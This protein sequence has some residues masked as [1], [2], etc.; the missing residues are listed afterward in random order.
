MRISTS[1]SR[2][3]TDHRNLDFSS[4]WKVWRF[5]FLGHQCGLE[6]NRKVICASCSTCHAWRPVPCLA[7]SFFPHRLGMYEHLGD[8]SEWF[9][10][11][12]Q[13]MSFDPLVA[14][15]CASY[16][17]APDS[18]A[19]YQG[20]E[21]VCNDKLKRRVVGGSVDHWFL[22][23]TGRYLKGVCTMIGM[24]LIKVIAGTRLINGIWGHAVKLSCN[25]H[26]G[27]S[28]FWAT[29]R[30]NWNHSFF[31]RR[32]SL[33]ISSNPLISKCWKMQFCSVSQ[34]DR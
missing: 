27:G 3:L 34:R 11:F 18:A 8:R 33:M 21:K 6:R 10:C 30:L 1:S 9:R 17:L 15:T 2:D 19:R 22:I 12:P 25:L 26:A 4:P 32:R 24:L 5:N 14:S 16:Y 28:G 13:S 31:R 20:G 7:G 29:A 23:T